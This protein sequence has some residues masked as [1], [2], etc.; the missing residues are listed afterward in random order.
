MANDLTS[1]SRLRSPGSTPAG[2]CLAPRYPKA[3]PKKPNIAKLRAR[4]RTGTRWMHAAYGRIEARR[5]HDTG[6]LAIRLL[7]HPGKPLKHFVWPF[8][9]AIGRL[10]RIRKA[11]P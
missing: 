3:L 5:V 6:L 2:V 8:Y 1:T 11:N 9:L 4:F 10:R 7:D